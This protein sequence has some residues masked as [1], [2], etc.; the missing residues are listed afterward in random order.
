MTCHR[1]LYY[2]CL[3]KMGWGLSDLISLKM[4]NIT[5]LLSCFICFVARAFVLRHSEVTV[6]KCFEPIISCPFLLRAKNLHFAKLL[7]VINLKV[8]GRMEWRTQSP[9][10]RQVLPDQQHFLWPDKNYARLFLNRVLPIVVKS[11]YKYVPV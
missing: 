3:K 8:K 10:S 6:L 5:L 11:L 7:K 9:V 4:N 1:F 2:S